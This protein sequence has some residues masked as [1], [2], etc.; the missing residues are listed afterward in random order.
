MKRSAAIRSSRVTEPFGTAEADRAPLLLDFRGHN[1]VAVALP[2]SQINSVSLRPGDGLII[3]FPEHRIAIRGRN[4]RVVYD[5][6][7]QQHLA[8]VQEDDFDDAPESA[9]FIDVI[10]I[11]RIQE[12]I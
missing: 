10:T 12:G 4:L 1:G 11:E 5:L 7:V 6:L 2:Y 3:D 8:Y 9:T